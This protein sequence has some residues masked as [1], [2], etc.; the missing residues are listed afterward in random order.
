VL[1]RE[2][3]G[4]IDTEIK[5]ETDALGVDI[6]NDMENYRLHLA[7]EKI[8]HF[9]WHRFADEIIEESKKKE[10]TGATLYYL[11][12]LSLR[13]LHPFMPFV[14]EEIWGL[15]KKKSLLIIERWPT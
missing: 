11:L 15:M 2:N 4:A 9:I 5:K 3:T 12:E 8:Y 6:T 14:T 7:A 10:N 1:S 13:L